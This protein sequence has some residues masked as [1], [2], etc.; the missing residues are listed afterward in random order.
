MI[1][2][3]QKSLEK[4]KGSWETILQSYNNQQ[5]QYDTGTNTGTYSIKQN[6]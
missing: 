3:R 6:K 1:L 2:N 5:K 4:R